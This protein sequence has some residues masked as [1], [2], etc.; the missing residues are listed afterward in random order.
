[1]LICVD[2]QSRDG[3]GRGHGAGLGHGNG[4]ER[5]HR[6]CREAGMQKFRKE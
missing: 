2:R 6:A 5:N 4:G 3:R 1:M